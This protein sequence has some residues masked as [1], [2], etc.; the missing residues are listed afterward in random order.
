VRFTARDAGDAGDAG[1]TGESAAL[2]ALA[3]SPRRDALAAAPELSAAQ[4]QAVEAID[5]AAGRY[6]A[7]LLQGAT[8][9]GKTEVYL[10]AVARC[11]ERGANAL[12]L[13]PE[14]GHAAAERRARL[15]CTAVLPGPE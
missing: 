7:F 9:S 3:A 12:V 1:A 8:G 5:A 13:V 6:E 4:L 10:R 14:I 11:L 2:A 15:R